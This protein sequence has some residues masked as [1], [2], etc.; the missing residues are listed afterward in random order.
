MHTQQ[1]QQTKV[2][3]LLEVMVVLKSLRLL[4]TTAQGGANWMTYN[5]FV[6]IIVQSLMA[7][8]F[9]SLEGVEQGE[10]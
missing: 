1:S 6:I 7:I 4:A 2:H 3:C 5:P 9:M 8:K 10:S